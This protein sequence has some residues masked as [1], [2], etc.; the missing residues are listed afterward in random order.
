MRTVDGT[1]HL[2]DPDTPASGRSA[3]DRV[4]TPAAWLAVASSWL[5]LRPY[6]GVIHDAQLYF[7]T[8]LFGRIQTFLDLD[9]MLAHDEQMDRSV[10]VPVVRP[11]VDAVGLA[12]AAVIV[13]IVNLVAW[14]AA[15]AWFARTLVGRDWWL[16]VVAVP[17]FGAYWGP[18][19]MIAEPFATPRGLAEALVLVGLALA[20]RQRYWLA[21]GAVV[22][23]GILH[24]IIGLSGAAV[25]AIIAAIDN[26]RLIPWLASGAVVGVLLAA[27]DPL[28][29]A[30]TESFDPA[31]LSVISERA[32]LVLPGEWPP[33]GWVRTLFGFA[34]VGALWQVTERAVIR[35]LSLIHI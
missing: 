27:W 12:T 23:A 34:V 13:T 18:L 24:P 32:G 14:I 3:L 28:V 5:I 25:V 31:W 1:Q 35:R 20:L 4:T 26:R 17:A 19:F 7:H 30:G 9:V 6:L 29:V 33:I 8:A 22:A 2:Q 15:L 10:F 16:V 11:L 21:A